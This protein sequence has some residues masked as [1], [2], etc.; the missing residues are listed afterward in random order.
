MFFRIIYLAEYL[1]LYVFTRIIYILPFNFSVKIG[2]ALGRLVYRLDERHR[3]IALENIASTL[4]LK[5]T[6]ADKIVLS[7]FENLGMVLAEFIKIP[8]IDK[9]FLDKSVSVEG[10]ENYLKAKSEGKGVLMLGAHL[11]NWELLGATLLLKMGEV[12]SVVYMKT[13]NPYVDRFIDSI[14]KSYGIKTIPHHNAMKPVLT[15]LRRGEAVGILLDQ[16]GGHKEAIKIDFIGRPA[17]TSMG[18]ALMAL[19]TGAPVV[20]MFMVRDGDDRF[21]FIYEKPIH[22]EKSGDLE[23]DIKDGTIIFNKV[24]EDYVRR[25]PEQWFW[26]HRRWKE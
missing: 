23:K 14:R 15:A 2:R 17:A 18:L 20:P 25:Y 21:R 10:F 16:H 24:I 13:K 7:V 1:L 5:G 11:G 9:S 22:L 8:T 12:A 19:R 6:E 4:G 3:R 26:V